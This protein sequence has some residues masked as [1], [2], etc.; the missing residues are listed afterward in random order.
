VPRVV[1]VGLLNSTD[2]HSLTSS[3][4]ARTAM[5]RIAGLWM[6]VIAVVVGILIIAFPD[7]IRWVL[8]IALI[9]LGVM[10]I[11]PALRR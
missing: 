5:L 8:G 4:E 1:A 6:G 11:I 7:F 9:V 10:A 3:K 2:I